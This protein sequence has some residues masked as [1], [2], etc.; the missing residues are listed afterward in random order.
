MA[1]AQTLRRFA[2]RPSASL[3]LLAPL[4]ERLRDANAGRWEIAILSADQRIVVRLIQLV[5]R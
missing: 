5:D 3:A 4:G 2:E 1:P